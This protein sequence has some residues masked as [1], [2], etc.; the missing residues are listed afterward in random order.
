MEETEQDKLFFA[1]LTA[2]AE[3][4]FPKRCNSCGRVFETADHFI[5]GSKA[6]RTGVTGLKQGYDD[7]GR[8]IVEVYRNCPCGSTLLDFFSNRRETSEEGQ[9]RRAL[10][11]T[12][13]SNLIDRGLN[14]V[15]ARLCLLRLLHGDATDADMAVFSGNKLP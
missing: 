9:Q 2:L 1:G 8:T 12:A 13:K 10:F 6:L 14:P 3:S 11:N 5:T 7:D 4:A 15:E